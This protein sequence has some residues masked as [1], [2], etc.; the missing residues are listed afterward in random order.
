MGW[1]KNV[2]LCTLWAGVSGVAHI[3]VYPKISHQD[4][5]NETF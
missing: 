3:I 5:S 4:L 2:D 1:T